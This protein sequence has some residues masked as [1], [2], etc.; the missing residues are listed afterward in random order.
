MKA[1]VY[2]SNTGTT[3][4]YAELL[5]QETKLPAYSLSEAKQ[6][7]PAGTEIFYLGWLMAGSVKGY[8]EA[9]KRYRVCAV[10]GVGMGRTGTQ[11]ADV[12]KKTAVP[13]GIPVFTL[14]GGFDIKKL[15]GI[16]RLMMLVME[17]TAGKRLAKKPDRTPEEDELLELLLHGG[18]RVSADNLEAVH[19][20]LTT[21][22]EKI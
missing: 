3:K 4:R 1:I 15:H 17:K 5:S 6:A 12:R 13:A 20:W 8:A 21:T 14:Q 18:E 10:C 16:Y 22:S 11:T 2:T 19:G 9:A 7:V